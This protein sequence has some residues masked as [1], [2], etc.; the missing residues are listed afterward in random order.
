MLHLY[1]HISY[2]KSE[3]ASVRRREETEPIESF[4][5][6]ISRLTAAEF[7]CCVFTPDYVMLAAAIVSFSGLGKLF[8]ENIIN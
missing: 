8:L 4:R 7:I 5:T 3:S 6:L 2:F 1:F